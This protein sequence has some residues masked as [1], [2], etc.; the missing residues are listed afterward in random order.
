MGNLS[1]KI[2]RERFPSVAVWGQLG[3]ALDDVPCGSMQELRDEVD[4]GVQAVFSIYEGAELVG[5][6]SVR[7]DEG[8]EASELVVT[9]AAGGL[10]GQSLYKLVTP[11]VE[12]LARAAGCQYLRGHTSRKGIGKL[13]EK[14]GWSQSEIIYR[15]RVDGRQFQKH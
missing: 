14:A 15:K 1:L 5:C 10:R 9:N 11:F 6:F 12:E 2:K 13:F 4:N 7:V 8:A 3:R